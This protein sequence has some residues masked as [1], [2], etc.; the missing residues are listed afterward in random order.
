M[1]MGKRLQILI[2][3]TGNYY[4]R[5]KDRF[6][7]H[8]VLALIDNAVEKQG[9]IIDNVLIISPMDIKKYN[10]DYIVVLVAQYKDIGMQL[11]DMEIA[12]S[13]IIYPTDE[14]KFGRFRKVVVHGKQV[15]GEILLISHEMNMRGA[16][17]MLLEMAKLIKQEGFLVH[18]A[19]MEYGD[20][21]D[22]YLIEGIPVMGFDDFLFSE[23]EIKRY[24]KD[25]KLI[26]VNTLALSDLIDRLASIDASVYWWIHEEWSA[27]HILNPKKDINLKRNNLHLY[28]VGNRAIRAFSEY[29]GNN[30]KIE[31]LQ[32][33]LPEEGIRCK[34][35]GTTKVIFAVIGSVCKIKGQD[36]LL[37]I[38][39][40]TKNKI[41]ENVQI[42]IIGD[43]ND[44]DRK[45]F[46]RYGECFKIWG[47][48]N[49][50][51]MLQLYNEV[52]IVMS[53]SRND[54][55]SVV[56]IEGMMNKKVCLT[57]DGT[58]V[59]DYIVN[60]ENGIVYDRNNK[61]NLLQEMIWIMN[62]KEQWE[63]I[64]EKAYKLYQNNFSENMFHNQIKEI[65]EWM[66]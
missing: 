26:I 38:V 44:A 14:K 18:V 58:G 17:L 15:K 34:K 49:H 41:F 46:E 10:Y 8:D 23:Q 40:E 62:H 50:D 37:E 12:E 16:P 66:E 61:E 33:G 63:D 30:K 45:Q 22:K 24:F 64:G 5:Y 55:M 47:E 42:W 19:A 2:W 51:D 11:T 48:V 27:Y 9:R 20:L 25:Y 36:I 1:I 28:G 56:L 65:I 31:N 3:G 54:T 29:F 21:G 4:Q 57:S 39:E 59:S 60:H 13:K 6:T 43:I 52:D 53:T 7:D 32:W 35:K